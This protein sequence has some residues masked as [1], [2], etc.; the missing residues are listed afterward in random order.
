MRLSG[1]DPFSLHLELVDL[2]LESRCVLADGTAYVVTEADWIR[3]L[4]FNGDVNAGTGLAKL[5]CR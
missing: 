4:D 2:E 1:L 5:G 3:R